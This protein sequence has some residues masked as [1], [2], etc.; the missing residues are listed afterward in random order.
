LAKVKTGGSIYDQMPTVMTAIT[1][2]DGSESNEEQEEE[3]K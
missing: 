3:L 1:I 2:S